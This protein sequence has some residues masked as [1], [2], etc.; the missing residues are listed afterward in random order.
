VEYRQ[1][2]MEELKDL[3]LSDKRPWIIGFSGGKDSTCVVQMV[4]YMLKD[5]PP[6]KRTKEVHIL[7]SDTLVENPIVGE[8]RKEV[9]AKIEKHAK[10]DGLP[11]KAKILRPELNDTFWVNL[12]GRGYPAPNKWF[13][14]CTDRLKINP[15]TKYILNQVKQSGEVIIL[16]GIRKSEGGIRVQTM[17][18]YEIQN[19]RLRRHTTIFGAYI[20]AP[21]ENWDVQNVWDYLLQFPSPW[22]DNNRDLFTLYQKCDTEVSFIIDESIP[23]SGSSR[24]GCW[25]CTVIDRDKSLEGLIE[26]GEA[27][28]EPLLAFRNWLKEIRD[29]PS[30]RE[31]TRKNDKKKKIIAEKLGRDF[32]PA[33]HRGHKVLGPFTFEA[34]HEIFRRLIKLH[35]QVA[36]RGLSLISPEEIKAI[37][38]MWIY[39]GDNISSITDVL[40]SSKMDVKS[41]LSET[42][43]KDWEQLSEICNE[44]GIPIHLIKQL[45]MVEKDL[46]S[47]S[48]RTGIYSRL[49][50]VIEEYII[51]EMKMENG[52]GK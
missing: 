35:E 37:E 48:R 3:Y 36:N 22:G 21:I 40:K 16:L 11:I 29:D 9:C 20:Y 2:T 31:D 43:I 19:F 41:S 30:M 32:I 42:D 1:K 12:I 5:L 13:R 26:D 6:D 4:Y 7:S 39:E 38:T 24:F 51:N 18:K 47:L 15:A 25:V 33:E 45:L 28:L 17:R 23:P 46:S 44:H 14:W 27:W 10:K 8:R 50:K 49:E 52:V 34:R